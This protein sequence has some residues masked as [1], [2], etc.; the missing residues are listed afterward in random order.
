MPCVELT[1]IRADMAT[2]LGSSDVSSIKQRTD[3]IAFLAGPVPKKDQLI[4]AQF[5]LSLKNF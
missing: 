5:K 1:L 2:T 3:I 4:A